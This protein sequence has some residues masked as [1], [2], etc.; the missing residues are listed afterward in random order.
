MHGPGPRHRPTIPPCQFIIVV[1]KHAARNLAVSKNA[2][3]RLFRRWNDPSNLVRGP[4]AYAVCAK[5]HQP[6]DTA[7][8]ANYSDKANGCNSTGCSNRNIGWVD[9]N[10]PRECSI[11]SRYLRAGAPKVSRCE[12][13]SQIANPDAVSIVT[14]D[15]NHLNVKMDKLR[16]IVYAF[17]AF[18]S[19]NFLPNGSRELPPQSIVVQL[20]EIIKV[21]ANNQWLKRAGSAWCCTP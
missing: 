21:A 17:A 9:R 8:G 1:R 20:I 2:N 5:R 10:E 15:N 7:R 13:S 12:R 14:S 16:Y 4:R 18:N 6:L 3:F 11:E 19:R